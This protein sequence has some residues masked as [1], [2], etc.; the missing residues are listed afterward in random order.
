MFWGTHAQKGPCG[1]GRVLSWSEL[2]FFYIDLYTMD[3]LKFR[4]FFGVR[5]V[6]AS[7]GMIFSFGSG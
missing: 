1:P 5:T 6:F 2:V 3:K 4:V 7:R